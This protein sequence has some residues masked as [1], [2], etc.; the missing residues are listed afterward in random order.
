MPWTV[1]HSTHRCSRH[2]RTP[3]VW[4]HLVNNPHN[5]SNHAALMIHDRT[6]ALPIAPATHCSK[7]PP[8]AA[9]PEVADHCMQWVLLGMDKARSHNNR[10]TSCHDHHGQSS[11]HRPLPKTILPRIFSSKCD[12]QCR[13]TAPAGQHK[14]ICLIQCKF[15]SVMQRPTPTGCCF[16]GASVALVASAAA[17]SSVPPTLSASAANGALWSG[18]N[19]ASCGGFSWRLASVPATS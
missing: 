4:L 8:A 3:A 18:S 2:I 1:T 6:G 12:P 19:C 9:E 7:K 11:K 15:K 5:P 17:A 10:H 13:N 16:S 14:R